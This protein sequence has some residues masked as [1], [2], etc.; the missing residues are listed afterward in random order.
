M[1][2]AV[3]FHPRWKEELVCRCTGGSF[4]LEF[5]MGVPTVYLPNKKRWAEVA[6]RW[7]VNSWDALHDKLRL[8]CEQNGIQLVVDETSGVYAPESF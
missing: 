1:T 8:W 4:V 7:A 6:P 2:F 3:S 5:T